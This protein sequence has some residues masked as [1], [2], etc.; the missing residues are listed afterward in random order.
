VYISLFVTPTVCFLVSKQLPLIKRSDISLKTSLGGDQMLGPI[1]MAGG[2]VETTRM[3]SIYTVMGESPAALQACIQQERG[4]SWPEDLSTLI[5]F[6]LGFDSGSLH[7]LAAAAASKGA[8]VFYADCYGII[9]YSIKEGRNLELMVMLI[10]RLFHA[11]CPSH[12]QS[13]KLLPLPRS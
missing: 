11:R 12:C 10:S 4:D 3:E 6:S 9:G 7:D 13:H 1:R 2:G 8:T 5:L